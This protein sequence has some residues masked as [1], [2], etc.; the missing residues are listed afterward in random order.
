MCIFYFLVGLVTSAVVYARWN[1]GKLEKVK[2][3]S[4]V[5]KPLFVGGSDVNIYK[6]LVHE[7]DDTFVRVYGKVYG[8]M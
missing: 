1:Y 8:V 7:Q 2:G 6:K 3:L 5:I 4:V